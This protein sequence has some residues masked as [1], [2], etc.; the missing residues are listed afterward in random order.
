MNIWL[1]AQLSPALAPWIA[2]RFGAPTTPLR[3]LG[4]RDSTD[5]EVFSAARHAGAT[6]MTKDDDFV[7]LLQELGVPPQIIWLTCGNTSNGE[8][9]RLLAEAGRRTLELLASG[10]PMVEISGAP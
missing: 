3:D 7:L 9:K 10:E 8:L 6:V 2:E 1:D 4:L 5:R